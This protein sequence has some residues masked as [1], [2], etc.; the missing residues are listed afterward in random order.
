ME[1]LIGA[2]SVNTVPDATLAAFRDHGE[3]RPSLAEGQDEAQAV[4]V[5]LGRHGIELDT[6]GNDLLSKGLTQ[7]E[8]AHASLLALLA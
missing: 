6:I 5:Q 2:D 4:L 7:F 8:Q 3:A 1:E